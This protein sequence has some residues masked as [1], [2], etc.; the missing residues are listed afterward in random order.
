MM[1][2]YMLV[3]FR[4]SPETLLAIVTPVWILFSVDGYDM[5]FET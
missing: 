1:S 5:P 4:R 3:L 2:H